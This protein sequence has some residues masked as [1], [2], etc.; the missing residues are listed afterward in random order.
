MGRG[1]REGRGRGE[2]PRGGAVRAAVPP[3]G[4]RAAP[5]P[6]PGPLCQPNPGREGRLAAD[7][8][9]AAGRPGR[10]PGADRGRW[11]SDGSKVSADGEAARPARAHPAPTAPGLGIGSESP[12]S[13]LLLFVC[14]KHISV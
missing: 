12:R 13:F 9:P 8:A 2:P 14:G 6:E 11:L 4:P 7:P 1:A 5:A 3:P 10:D